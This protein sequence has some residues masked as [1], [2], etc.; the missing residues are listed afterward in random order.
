MSAAANL[1]NRLT[2]QGI[3]LAAEPEGIRVRPASLL[4]A[5]LRQA[6]L[7]HKADLLALLRQ[8][9]GA[10]LPPWSQAAADQVL[11]DIR[12]TIARLERGFP[13]GR[14]PA[15]VQNLMTDAIANAERLIR[16]HE[17]EAARGWDALE[18]LCGVRQLVQE[19]AARARRTLAALGGDHR[20][21][22]GKNARPGA[23]GA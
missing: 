14:F 17:M 20:P 11:A 2:R 10:A 15:P 3:S 9:A 4:T 16:D 18:L 5:E 19:V 12:A 22:Q 7:A 23:A 21:G 13:G 1:L 8:P 6:I